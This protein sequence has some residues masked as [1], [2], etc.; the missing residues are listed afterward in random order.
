VHVIDVEDGRILPKES[1][2]K[3]LDELGILYKPFDGVL[4]KESIY[5][6][7]GSFSVVQKFL[8]SEYSIG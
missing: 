5:L 2:Y 8:T 3:A 6:V 4:D 1:L 7:F